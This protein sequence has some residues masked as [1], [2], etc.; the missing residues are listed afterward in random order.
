[1]K[2]EQLS[3]EAILVRKLIVYKVNNNSK[4]GN[5]SRSDPFGMAIQLTTV[6][7]HTS[8]VA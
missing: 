6:Q 1:M 2:Y 8:T 4:Y 3:L 7:R 5:F